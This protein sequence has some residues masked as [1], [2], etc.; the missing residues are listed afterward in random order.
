MRT[1]TN[2]GATPAPGPTT[3]QYAYGL[4]FVGLLLAAIVTIPVWLIIPADTCAC[5]T[6]ADMAVYNADSRAITVRWQQPGLLGTPLFGHSA[7]REVAAC[8][9]TDLV[10]P[11]GRNT[12]SV[13]SAADSAELAIEVP[14]GHGGY[15]I[16]IVVVRTGGTVERLDAPPPE[17]EVPVDGRCGT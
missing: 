12:V 9:S 17:A 11:V 8:T 16:P 5:T 2:A 7:S 13:V 3:R 14:P 15:D 1:D 10:I 6:P 4:G